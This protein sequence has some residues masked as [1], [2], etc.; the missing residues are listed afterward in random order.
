MFSFREPG[1]H[2]GSDVP[3]ALTATALPD[4]L[5]T[6]L[7]HVIRQADAYVPALRG[8]LC[9]SPASGPSLR[10]EDYVLTM[11][12]KIRPVLLAMAA[13]LCVPPYAAAQGRGGGR[14]GPAPE[15]E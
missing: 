10:P 13:V 8:G 7:H 15:A 14:G 2:M 4:V 3:A 11:P 9:N 6:P 5:T 12:K 1:E